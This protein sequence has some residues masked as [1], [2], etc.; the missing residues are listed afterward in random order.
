MIKD[1]LQI[2]APNI[3]KQ[4]FI[5]EPVSAEER[6]CLTLR[7][8]ASGDSMI[9]MSSIFIRMY[10]SKQHYIRN[11]QSNLEYVENQC[12]FPHCIGAIDGKHIVIQCPANAGSIYYN[13]KHHHSIVLMAMCDANYLFTFI[14]IGA[15]GRRSDGGIFAE[16]QFGKKFE[17]KR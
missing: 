15:Y 14:D 16:Y 6:L 7:Y 12:N 5:R 3:Q 1:L 13:Y 17:Q 11:M 8:L 9:S 4:T 10:N 2:I